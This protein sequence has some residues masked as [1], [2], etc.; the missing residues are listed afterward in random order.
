MG[1][2]GA[3]RV[4]AL[5]SSQ[6]SAMETHEN[7][8]DQAAKL[9][10]KRDVAALIYSPY[11]IGEL[12]T[13]CFYEVRSQIEVRDVN[14]HLSISDALDLHVKDA[15]KNKA[16]KKQ[17]LHALVQFPTGLEVDENMELE[18]LAEAIFFINLK[19]GEQAVFHAR[20]DRDEAGRH[21]VDVFFAP[22]Y[23]KKTK[24]KSEEWV[25][26]TKFGKALARD[27]IGQKPQERR[28]ETTKQW[29]P[30]ETTSGEPK[31]AW[32]DSQHYQGQALQQAWHEH[33][34]DEMELG[35]AVR[36]T[37]KLGRDTDRLEVEEYKLRKDLEKFEKTK[38]DLSVQEAIVDAKLAVAERLD[39]AISL[40]GGDDAPPLPSE[41]FTDDITRKCIEAD[42]CP[43]WGDEDR[44]IAPIHFEHANEQTAMMNV[45]EKGSRASVLSDI[46]H[47]GL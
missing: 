20:L 30:V 31:M 39:T 34:V 44:S 16:A 10:V 12:P 25:S 40:I 38:G 37:P 15:R 13:D 5:D 41:L 2:S 9:R 18:M 4:K 8:A 7:R 26:L 19:H 27:K 46:Q 3:V 42:P 21:V 28:C 14:R 24:R 6:I 43:L 33:L 36:G 17:C 45:L 23:I 11:S 22:K 47:L 1:K 35:W 32:C 29:L